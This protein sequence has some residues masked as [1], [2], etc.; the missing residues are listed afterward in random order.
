M[1]HIFISY[2]KKDI[3]FA[4]YLRA[5]IEQKGYDVW[6]DE[7]RLSAGDSWWQTIED[8]IIKSDAVIVI[9]SVHSAESRWVERE[10]L[11]AEKR[12]CSIFPVLLSGDAWSRL[13]ELQYE[14]MRAGLRATLS[15]GFFAKLA[16]NTPSQDIEF[17]IEKED[18]TRFEADVIALKHAR[19]FMGADLAVVNLL[20]NAEIDLNQLQPDIDEYVLV[21]TQNAIAAPQALFIGTPYKFD[22]DCARKL[23]EQTLTTLAD[24]TPDIEHIAMTIHGVGLGLDIIKTLQSQMLGFISAIEAGAYPPSLKK[25]TIVERSDRQHRQLLDIFY[26]LIVPEFEMSPLINGEG[27]SIQVATI[28]APVIPESRTNELH[29]YVIMAND[30]RLEDLFYYGIQTPVHQNGLLCG[31]ISNTS[32][33]TTDNEP[34]YERI[35]DAAL[36]IV[37]AASISEHELL[38]IGYAYG[39]GVPVLFISGDDTVLPPG[40]PEDDCIRY[41]RIKTLEQQLNTRIADIL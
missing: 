24:L 40:L 8:N 37:D 33:T 5:Q 22:Y 10:I 9:M 39:K 31:R 36:L 25:I 7:K 27:G 23:A 29:A 16:P 34:F 2:S 4:R 6:M 13:A 41:S 35:H 26:S 32:D 3:E 1:A 11:L 15:L 28:A 18:I 19:H 21:D 20:T 17:H 30:Q 38:Q 12:N 14:D